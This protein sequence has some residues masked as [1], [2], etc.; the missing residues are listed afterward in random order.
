MVEDREKGFDRT[1]ASLLPT[2]HPA[3]HAS[4]RLIQRFPSAFRAGIRIDATNGAAPQGSQL[5]RLLSSS[6]TM[7]SRQNHRSWPYRH[8]APASPPGPRCGGR[9]SLRRCS[10]SGRTSSIQRS[11]CASR[12]S[13]GST[14]NA[15]RRERVRGQSWTTFPRFLFAAVADRRSLRHA[16]PRLA[17]QLAP[18]Q[19][20]DPR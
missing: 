11:A 16:S 9:M 19:P 2:S 7:W 12:D 10:S 6:R 15:I 17:R 5:P 18:W 8:R 1:P 13:T 14:W 3:W 4:R 20:A